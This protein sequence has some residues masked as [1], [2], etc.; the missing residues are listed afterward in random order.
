VG[1][2][3][4]EL[5]ITKIKGFWTIYF[6]YNGSQYFL[7]DSGDG[8][9]SVIALYK[10]T[11][12][13]NGKYYIQWLRGGLWDTDLIGEFINKDAR[14]KRTIVYSHINIEYFMNKLKEN[15]FWEVIN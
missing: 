10:R 1:L 11:P 7:H 15:N 8:Y 3:V 12:I 6:T 5:K 9:E 4:G 13:G 14:R 2:A